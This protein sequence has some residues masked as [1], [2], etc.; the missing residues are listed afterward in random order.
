LA[1]LKALYRTHIIWPRRR[2][3]EEAWL[4]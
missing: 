2:A 1:Y 3:F 4:S